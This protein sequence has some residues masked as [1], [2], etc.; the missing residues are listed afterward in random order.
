MKIYDDAIFFPA[1]SIATHTQI[2][3]NDF[4]V[5]GKSPRFYLNGM[6]EKTQMFH[7]P[8]ILT[9]AYHVYKNM[10]FMKDIGIEN[11]KKDTNMIFGDSGGFQI[12]TGQLKST[13]EVLTKLYDW[14][15]TNATL[16]PI[17]DAPPWSSENR[18]VENPEMDKGIAATK[19]NIEL[20]LSRPNRVKDF[21]WLNVSHGT[22][23][24]QRKY[25]YNAVKDYDFYDGWA[26]GSLK[27]NAYA[28]LT[29]FSNLMDEGELEKDRCKLIHFFAFTSTQF[30]PIAIYLKHK[31]N[32]KGYKINISF[33]SSYATQNG[34]WGKYLIYPSSSG[35]MS[36]HLSNR[37]LD[38]FQDVP[39]PCN[40]P[41]CK[42]I[43]LK[44][45]YNAEALKTDG[46][47]YFYN[48]VQSHNVYML[49]EYVKM[50]HSLI[51]TDCPELWT[52]CFK[53]K[54]QRVFKVIDAMFEAPKGQA[55]WIVER[56]YAFLSS[57]IEIPPENPDDDFAKSFGN[58]ENNEDE[59]AS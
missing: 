35:F 22:S 21:S 46:E 10:E 37:F 47:S 20:L 19:A 45:M 38:K 48:V 52:T 24:D 28:I 13:P 15:E 12:A 9:S 5:N 23:Y 49:A 30:M 42:G 44:D 27:K 2:M 3:K 58:K 39:M 8:Y 54:Q 51:Y 1:I 41:V 31:L 18:L 40:C 11:P 53:T 43:R 17:I 50:L 59:D 4:K 6:N 36:Y 25:W 29:A 14:M 34:G 16:S 55:H 26:L 33:D 57:F 56:D 7:H 32:R